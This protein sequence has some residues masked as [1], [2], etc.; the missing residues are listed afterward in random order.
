MNTALAFA[1]QHFPHL[2]WEEPKT[3]VT[4]IGK[5]QNGG[6]WAEGRA[7][8]EEYELTILICV[9]TLKGSQ[10]WSCEVTLETPYGFIWDDR[11]LNH[12][13]NGPEFVHAA[14]RV[15]LDDFRRHRRTEEDV[16]SDVHGFVFS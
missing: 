3:T 13:G 10:V 12:R 4:R 2:R 16:A 1:Q 7:T 9:T 8:F 5:P 6:E 15:V 11:T 14:A